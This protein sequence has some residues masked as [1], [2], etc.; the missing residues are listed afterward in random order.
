VSWTQH[1]S[2]YPG[3]ASA[4]TAGTVR[5]WSV[6][7]TDTRAYGGPVSI[8]GSGTGVT[9]ASTA[10]VAALT[11]LSLWGVHGYPVLDV[12]TAI[13]AVAGVPALLRFI[14]TAYGLGL[15]TALSPVATPAATVGVLVT[16]R[17]RPWREAVPVAAVGLA[18]QA[19]QG[20]WRPR[21]GIGYGWWL[22][23]LGVAYAGLLGWGALWRAR[24][25][26]LASLRQQAWRAEAD[27]ERRITEARRGE[28]NRI[29]REMHDVLA[30]R[31][32]LVATY[33]GALEF[34]PDSAPEQLAAAAGVV[35]EGVHQALDE[36]RDVIAV[37][38][39]GTDD[40]LPGPTLAAIPELVEE[41][42][43]AGQRVQLTNALTA[44]VPAAGG[45]AAYR[46]VQEALT[47]ARKHAPGPPVTVAIAGAPGDGLSIEVTNP[48]VGPLAPGGVGLV[49]LTE[50]VELAGGRLEHG[51]VGGAFRLAAWLPWPL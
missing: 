31:L 28:R 43:R 49:G 34:R 30:H 11:A 4:G 12:V 20:W 27:Q 38:R 39:E 5:L 33:A 18:A 45:R 32:S 24:A 23:L 50:R 16:A 29:A 6:A 37:L 17:V 36:L 26:L 1:Q 9:V 8:R 13:L 51:A 2:G 7:G 48:L 14:P 10:G 21:G 25:A 22:L 42:T 40:D 47:N 41:A 3:G 35:R 44:E 19:V 15:L 46:V